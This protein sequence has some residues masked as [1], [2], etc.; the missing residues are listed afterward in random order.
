MHLLGCT[1]FVCFSFDEQMTRKKYI[2]FEICYAFVQVTISNCRVV[3]GRG[4]N[5]AQQT[6][7]AER[8]QPIV[9]K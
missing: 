6:E 2:N 3:F 5:H 1:Q 4:S 9:V 7:I 8:K